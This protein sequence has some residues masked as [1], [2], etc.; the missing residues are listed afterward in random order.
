MGNP[1]YKSA[2]VV[3]LF[4]I[5]NL[6]GLPQIIKPKQAYISHLTD[7]TTQTGADSL[8]DFPVSHYNDYNKPNIIITTSEAK[9]FNVNR[10][11]ALYLY[12]FYL[13][14]YYDDIS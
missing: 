8:E 12:S 7:T 11:Y 5:S 6:N 13:T 2:A 14:E 9:F 3:S 4:V 1:D 10:N